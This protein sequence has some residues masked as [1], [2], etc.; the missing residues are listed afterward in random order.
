L[1]I[2]YR[3]AYLDNDEVPCLVRWHASSLEEVWGP[4]HERRTTSVLNDPSERGDLCTAEIDPLKAIEIASSSAVSL[5]EFICIGQLDHGE[6]TINGI[7][8]W[9]MV[10]S[11]ELAQSLTSILVTTFANE[12]P[13]RLL[14]PEGKD[15]DWYW[16]NPL[17]TEW[18]SD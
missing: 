13:W 5:A 4:L 1:A 10:V 11:D 9:S 14:C 17:K 18:D 3:G 7:S 2:R 8:L 15:E 16:E 6:M 12:P